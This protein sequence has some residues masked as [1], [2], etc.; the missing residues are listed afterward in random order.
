MG[1]KKILMLIVILFFVAIAVAL[2]LNFI[3]IGFSPSLATFAL[4]VL[5]V[6]AFLVSAGA[7]LPKG[8]RSGLTTTTIGISLL[9]LSVLSALTISFV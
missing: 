6:G 3:V 9:V 5:G 7:V 8:G 2:S 4:A 1:I